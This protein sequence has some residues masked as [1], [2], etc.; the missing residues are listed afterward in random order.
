MEVGVRDLRNNLSRYLDRVKAGEELVVT[1]RGAAIA[2][3]MPIEGER[4]LDAL[5]AD[6]LVTP[7][8]HSKRRRKPPVKGA[9]TVSDLVADQRR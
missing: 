4:R 1:D 3:V 7:A 2:R 8:R 9:G 6:G 5:I